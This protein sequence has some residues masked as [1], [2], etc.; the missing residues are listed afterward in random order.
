VK[1]PEDLTFPLALEA[2]ER[3]ADDFAALVETKAHNAYYE[4]PATL[5]LL[6]DVAGRRVLDAGCG[7]GVYAEW[8]LAHGADVVCLDVSPRMVAITKERLGG[9]ATVL[10]ADL[11]R[12][13]DFLDDASFDVVLAALV[14][15]YVRD[16]R[17]LFKEFH[18][19]LGPGGAFVF[20][21]EHPFSD[22]LA[23][24]MTDYFET[25]VVECTWRGFRNPV[26]VRSLRR[27]LGELVASLVESGFT[28]DRFLEPLPTDEFKT[29]DPE[30]Y[31]KLMH[32]PGFLCVRV[33]KGR[34][35]ESA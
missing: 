7:P 8:L 12:S 25:E 24:R 5:S 10:R 1:R 2:Y 13:L 11:D 23:R 3:L 19:L 26:P 30:E 17:S 21:L 28:I 32:R 27:P 22:F 31:D 16:W 6:P 35:H 20:S 9:R 34:D 4:R 14:V 18:R 15:D 29:A 33:T